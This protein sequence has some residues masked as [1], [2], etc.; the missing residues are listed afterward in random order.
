MGCGQHQRAAGRF[1]GDGVCARCASVYDLDN[2]AACVMVT[3]EAASDTLEAS[4]QVVFVPQPR[5]EHLWP[6]IQP[7]IEPAVQRVERNL[8]V[9]DV[10]RDLTEGRSMALAVTKEDKL[11]A[12]VIVA[13][14]QHPRRTTLQIQFVG[15]TNM[16]T[17]I[18]AAMA[19]IRAL[20]KFAGCAGIEADARDGWM[21]HADKIGFNKMWTH[22]EM[23]I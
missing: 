14:V 13:H 3:A 19:E 2:K 18:G 23:E 17:W 8:S 21:R 5:V 20:A 4:I 11:I 12:T 9:D 6:H 1:C 7:L 22:Y 16:K 15:G 10:R